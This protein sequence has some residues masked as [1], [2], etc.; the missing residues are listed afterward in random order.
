VSFLCS[1]CI[2]QKEQ[3]R[4]LGNGPDSDLEC[5]QSDPAEQHLSLSLSLSLSLYIPFPFLTLTLSRLVFLQYHQIN[6]ICE[7]EL[8]SVSEG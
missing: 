5:Y 6:S 4:L 8:V 7:N 1:C 3:Q 2:D